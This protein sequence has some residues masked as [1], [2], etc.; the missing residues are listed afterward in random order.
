MHFVQMISKYT[1][2][3]KEK[4]KAQ[5]GSF[6]IFGAQFSYWWSIIFGVSQLHNVFFW[7]ININ[8]IIS[9]E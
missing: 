2:K 4:K 1:F 9:L 3:K 5:L 7:N 6:L 8:N